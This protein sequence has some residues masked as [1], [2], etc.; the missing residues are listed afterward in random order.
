MELLLKGRTGT[1]PM[2]GMG[3]ESAALGGRNGPWG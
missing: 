2:A 3:M 1:E